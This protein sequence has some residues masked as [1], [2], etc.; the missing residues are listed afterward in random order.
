MDYNR[1]ADSEILKVLAFPLLVVLV[2]LCIATT[3]VLSRALAE[4]WG[5][6]VQL[7]CTTSSACDESDS[8]GLL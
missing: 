3:G 1:E 4:L 2:L 5:T 8:D 6:V 7:Y